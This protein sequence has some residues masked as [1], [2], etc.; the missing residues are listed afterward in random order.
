MTGATVFA[1]VTILAATG[2]LIA[3]G[4][5]LLS[6]IP[7]AISDEFSDSDSRTAAIANDVG[8]ATGGNRITGGEGRN[9]TCRS[10]IQGS[11]STSSVRTAEQKFPS[12]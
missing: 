6:N 4:D 12:R 9:A 1:G 11:H 8:E 7:E 2:A 10:D 5:W 3:F